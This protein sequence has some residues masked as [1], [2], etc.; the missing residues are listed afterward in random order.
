MT[1]R[2]AAALAASLLL[3]MAAPAVAGCS[4]ASS[5]PELKVA[6]AYM[7]Q[8]V[9]DDLAGGYLVVTNTGDTAD[10]LTSVTSGLAEDITLHESAGETM[11]QVDSFTVPANGR[12]ELKRGGSHLMFTGLARKPAQGERVSIE[13]HFAKSDP[14][15]ADVPVE[16]ATFN[17]RT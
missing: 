16:T 14:L 11:R 4:S 8:P 10:E 7:P 13:L 12:L 9:S 3:L 6:S 15:T 5:G 2:R 1:R 17:P